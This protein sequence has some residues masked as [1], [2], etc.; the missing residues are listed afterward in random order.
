MAIMAPTPPHTTRII[1]AVNDKEVAATVLLATVVTVATAVTEAR[2]QTVLYPTNERD[3]IAIPPPMM[4]MTHTIK[5]K[6]LKTIDVTVTAREMTAND[7]AMIHHLMMM[8]IIIVVLVMVTPTGRTHETNNLKSN[9]SVADTTR[10]MKMRKPM[11]TARES[12]VVIVM[13][14]QNRT[15]TTA[16]FEMGIEIVIEIEEAIEG[17]TVIATETET[18][19]ETEMGAETEIDAATAIEMEVETET[20]TETE[21]EMETEI[22]IE[23]AGE[24]GLVIGTGTAIVATD[25]QRTNIPLRCSLF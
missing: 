13:R 17:E 7:V 8:I 18:E 14:T 12:R 15:A 6:A 16:E 5:A 22:E 21:I 11:E 23:I 9:Q 10:L 1:P 19:T 3:T 4:P 20:E 2:E 24:M 25:K